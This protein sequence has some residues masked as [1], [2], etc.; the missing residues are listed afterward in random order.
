MAI[1]FCIQKSDGWAEER[2]CILCWHFWQK[3]KL[4]WKQEMRIQ[5]C[6]LTLDLAFLAD[7]TEQL[8]NLN[9]ELQGKGKTI[10][11]MISAVKAKLG[12]FLQQVEQRKMQHLPS[13]HKMLEEN[14]TAPGAMDIQKYIDLLTRLGQ[15]FKDRFTDIFRGWSPVPH[16]V[17]TPSWMWTYV[18]FLNRW[19]RCLISV[20]LIWRWTFSVCKM[21]SSWSHI[22]LFLEA[23]G[24]KEVPQH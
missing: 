19:V 9:C 11:E 1:F 23:C 18:T 17:Q 3:S 24:C 20:L 6:C 15:E 13:V 4:S 8:N 10:S 14:D 16:L 12:R 5:L 22:S 21:T 2:S 7:V